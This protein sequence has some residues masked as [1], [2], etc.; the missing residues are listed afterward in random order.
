MYESM[1]TSCTGKYSRVFSFMHFFGK[2]P[3]G[4]SSDWRNPHDT[5][6]VSSHTSFKG[7]SNCCAQFCASC[8]E[9]FVFE[10]YTRLL[11]SIHGLKHYCWVKYLQGIDL[12]GIAM[13]YGG[14]LAMSSFHSVPL[15]PAP[16]MFSLSIL[17]PRHIIASWVSDPTLSDD[18]R[19]R[20]SRWHESIF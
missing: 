15:S 3:K 1:V 9:H 7:N 10:V 8:G 19:T 12:Q 17:L 16:A 6:T 14:N 5:V 20:R 18:R 4:P 13:S 2:F 11:T